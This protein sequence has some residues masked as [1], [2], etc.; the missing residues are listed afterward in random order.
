MKNLATAYTYDPVAKTLTLTGLNVPL[1]YLL[2]VVNATRG[3]IIYNLAD[4]S[5]AAANYT[6]GANSVLTLNASVD[7]SFHD[8]S[9]ALT[10]FYDDG[11]QT[12]AVLIQG[13]AGPKGEPG[14][15]GST[16]IENITG[17]QD[18]LDG[19][20]PALE[21]RSI[22]L[23]A[24]ATSYT[25][26]SGRNIF[27]RVIA[28]GSFPGEILLPRRTDD[29]AQDGDELVI[30]TNNISGTL[31]I[32]RYIFTGSSYISAT[33]TFASVT[34]GRFTGRFRL[35]N[36]EWTYLD[37]PTHERLAAL[38]ARVLALEAAQAP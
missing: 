1:S 4:P 18:A 32:K 29:A 33:E 2:L 37:L 38:E 34:G 12:N 10:I 21:F 20:A 25:L 6:Q 19:K 26:T 13:P 5:L 35:M 11:I 36:G 28:N 8:A 31:S 3:T 30:T 16:E 14:D 23:A 27:L 24:A 9:D 7:T 15:P 22:S 17:L